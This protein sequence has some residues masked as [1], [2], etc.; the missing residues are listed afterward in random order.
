MTSTILS[1]VIKALRNATK[2]YTPPLCNSIIEIYGKDA[3]LILISCLLSLRA[4]DSMS[5]HICKDL[6]SK[7][8]TPQGILNIPLGELEKILFRIGFYK[9]KARTLHHVCAALLKSFDGKVP[10]TMEELLSIKGVGRKTANLVLGLAFDEP[11]LCVDIHVHRISNRLG[12]VKT[13]T[14][15]ET[16]YAL[17]KILPKEYWVEWN[18]L[19]VL[20]GQNNC[21]PLSPRCT[22]CIIRPHCKQIGVTKFR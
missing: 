8:K 4:K 13:K 11:A 12:L 19:L 2:H 22:S 16:E 21:T 1:D 3:F 9:N 14:P 10:R 20:W 18:Y 15:E 5:I 7:A 17:Q 6:F